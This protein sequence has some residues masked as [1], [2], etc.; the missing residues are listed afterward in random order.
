LR[1]PY[2]VDTCTVGPSRED[3]AGEGLFAVRA[4]GPGELCAAYN[5]IR[6]T[7]AEVDARDWALNENTCSLDDDVVLDVPPELAST[8]VYC[9]SLGHKANHAH[10]NNAEYAPFIHPR[11]GFIKSVR[12]ISPIAAGEEITVDYGYDLEGEDGVPGWYRAYCGRH[13][14]GG[15]KAR[16]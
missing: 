11:F 8:Q 9:A 14:G 4:I 6:L 3:G 5:G 13:G 15:K 1:D 10:D 2:E 16:R 7:H 12:A